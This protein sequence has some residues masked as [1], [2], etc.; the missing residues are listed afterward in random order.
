MI[1]KVSETKKKH[2]GA[3]GGPCE[4]VREVREDHCEDYAVGVW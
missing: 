2:K 3:D 4:E 1:G